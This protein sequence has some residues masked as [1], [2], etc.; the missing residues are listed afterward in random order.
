MYQPDSV[1]DD[2]IKPT[3]RQLYGTNRGICA[4]IINSNGSS[5]QVI[6][7]D[8]DNVHRFKG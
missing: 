5:I 8:W 4:I 3:R 1:R 6:Y 7:V 2:L